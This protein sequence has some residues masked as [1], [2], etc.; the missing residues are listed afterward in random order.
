VPHGD[1][2]GDRVRLVAAAQ[3]R[4]RSERAQRVLGVELLEDRVV[5]AHA[6]VGLAHLYRPLAIQHDVNAP[7]ALFARRSLVRTSQEPGA[8][9]PDPPTSA[10]AGGVLAV[11]K[12]L[13]GLVVSALGDANL[14]V[15][16]AFTNHLHVAHFFSPVT[17]LLLYSSDAITPEVRAVCFM[18]TPSGSVRNM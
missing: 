13:H 3:A 9:L 18:Q 2:P 5:V 1:G 12:R 4:R 7:A 16:N 11:R 14:H 15:E 6:L 17:G 8:L 10:G